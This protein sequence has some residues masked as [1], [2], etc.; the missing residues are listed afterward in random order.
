[1]INTFTT[2][3]PIKNGYN[4]N[5]HEPSMCPYL[6]LIHTTNH[7]REKA[8]SSNNNGVHR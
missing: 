3:N 4:D 1:M 8:I 5:F 6:K 7:S 2:L